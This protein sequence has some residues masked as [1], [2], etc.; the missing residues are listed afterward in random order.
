MLTY[1]VSEAGH[2]AISPPQDQ[3]LLEP[4]AVTHTSPLGLTASTN[5][6]LLQLWVIPTYT[7]WAKTELRNIA[8]EFPKV[9]ENAHRFAK[10]FYILI[11]NYQP[12]F[13]GLYQLIHLLV[14]EG[15]VQ[16]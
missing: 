8:K 15:H 14:G 2:K 11:Q 3:C 1:L 9:T 10:E 16:H 5:H 12:V 7:P 13:S 6:H 4:G